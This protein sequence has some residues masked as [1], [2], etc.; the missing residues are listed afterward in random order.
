M[1]LQTDLGAAALIAVLVGAM[2]APASAQV[3]SAT[4]M[5][6]TVPKAL[7]EAGESGENLYDAAKANDWTGARRGLTSLEAAVKRVAV[8][9]GAAGQ[10]EDSLGRNLAALN[11]SVGRRQRRATMRLANQVTLNVA[12]MTAPYAPRIPVQV[13]RLDFYGRELEI[14]SEAGDASQLKATAQGMRREWEDVRPVVE[15]RDSAEAKKFGAL[16]T[17]VER[18]GTPA[19]DRRLAEAVLEEVDNLE[20]A[21]ER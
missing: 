6:P 4:R 19:A 10:A 7:A 5:R 13:T 14:W 18:A 17:R 1:T 15:G 20:K 9:K 16:V 3:D 8:E 2:S 11:R 12:D 21:F